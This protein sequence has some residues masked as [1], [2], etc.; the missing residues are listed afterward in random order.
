MLRIVK[1]H[2]AGRQGDV[3]DLDYDFD[4]RSGEKCII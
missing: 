4:K 2:R 3:R 1:P